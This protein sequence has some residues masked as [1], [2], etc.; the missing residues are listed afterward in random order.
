MLIWSISYLKHREL[1]NFLAGEGFELDSAGPAAF[2]K[3]LDG[4]IA[5]YIALIP[6]ID[7]LKVE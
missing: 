3:F 7:G 2:A 1:R 6:A 5:K 4:E